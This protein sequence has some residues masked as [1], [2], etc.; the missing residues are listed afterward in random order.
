MELLAGSSFKPRVPKERENEPPATCWRCSPAE[1]LVGVG[2]ANPIN[3]DGRT[4]RPDKGFHHVDD[5]TTR[6]KEDTKD[7]LEGSKGTELGICDILIFS[8]QYPVLEF[9]GLPSLFL[10]FPS[11]FFQW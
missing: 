9:D 10:C 11:L 2:A 4:A 5:S 1:L 6:S 7:F 3:K 8:K